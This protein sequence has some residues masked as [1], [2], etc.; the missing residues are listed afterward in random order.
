MIVMIE[1]STH[2]IAQLW[3]H[4]DTLLKGDAFDALDIEY[5]AGMKNVLETLGIEKPKQ[6]QK[7][8]RAALEA[9]KT[10]GAA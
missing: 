5:A 6:P 10:G 4:V 9:E 3:A 2:T 8:G 7:A 1:A